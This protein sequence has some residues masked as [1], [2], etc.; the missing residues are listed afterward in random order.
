MGKNVMSQKILLRKCNEWLL[1]SNQT[2]KLMVSRNDKQQHP[3]IGI[4]LQL[5]LS[6]E[7]QLLFSS[8]CCS[9]ASAVQQQLWHHLLPRQAFRWR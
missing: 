6:N 4:S 5:L 2:S 1:L 3:T 8:M 7:K 9:A